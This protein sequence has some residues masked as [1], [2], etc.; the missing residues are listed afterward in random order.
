[1]IWFLPLL[2]W[3]SVV[4]LIVATIWQ[5]DSYRWTGVK[6]RLVRLWP[7]DRRANMHLEAMNG[8]IVAGQSLVE[9]SER[10]LKLAW[11][12]ALPI[13]S[14]GLEAIVSAGILIASGFLLRSAVLLQ[15]AKRKVKGLSGLFA[16][17]G[18]GIY[19][20][21]RREWSTLAKQNRSSLQYSAAILSILVVAVLT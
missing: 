21:A 20:R 1:M 15:I 17:D 7:E 9:W 16:Y 13:L 5:F 19:E 10:L 4:V 14:Q 3:L 6:D 2:S 8:F 12:P 18:F 11:I